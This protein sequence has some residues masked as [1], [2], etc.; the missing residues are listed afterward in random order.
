MKRRARPNARFIT[1]REAEADY[2]IS[3]AMLYSWVNAGQLPRLNHD[4]AGRA[5]LI[6]RADLDA[7]LD[8]NITKAAS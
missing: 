1:L 3:Y 6:R 2:G 4:V 8:A 7:F 5:I